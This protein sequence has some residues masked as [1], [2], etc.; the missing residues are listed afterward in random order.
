MTASLFFLKIRSVLWGREGAVRCCLRLYMPTPVGW[1]YQ[2]RQ[3][4]C[5]F[6]HSTVIL[7]LWCPWTIFSLF[8]PFAMICSNVPLSL[9]HSLFIN[10]RNGLYAVANRHTREY[11]IHCQGFNKMGFSLY[12]RSQHLSRF[13]FVLC[14]LCLYWRRLCTKLLCMFYLISRQ[15]VVSQELVKISILDMNLK[16]THY[17][18]NRISDGLWINHK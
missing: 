3:I 7:L 1:I 18:Y 16:I 6:G 11:R 12:R 15:W 5:R 13:L 8:I 17:D 4:T 14:T 9:F 10:S 2:W